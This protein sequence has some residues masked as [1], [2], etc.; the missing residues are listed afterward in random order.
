MKKILVLLLSLFFVSC[1]KPTK[2]IK[3]ANAICKK[4]CGGYFNGEIFYHKKG[5]SLGCICRDALKVKYFYFGNEKIKIDNENGRDF[6]FWMIWFQ[7]I[8]DE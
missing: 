8:I 1:I 4:T 7:T 5:I 6:I 2:P 3:E